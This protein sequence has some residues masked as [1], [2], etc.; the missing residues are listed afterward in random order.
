[1]LINLLFHSMSPKPKV[2]IPVG[3]TLFGV[4]TFGAASVMNR[5][6]RIEQKKEN[7][8][9]TET[10]NNVIDNQNKIR[11]ELRSVKESAKAIMDKIESLNN[12]KKEFLNNIDFIPTGED[13]MNFINQ[14]MEF[15]SS[16]PVDNSLLIFNILASLLILTLLISTLI[17]FYSNY[18]IAYFK[19][20]E[21]YPKLKIFLE[22][23]MKF[24]KFY[25]FY[26]IAISAFL[27]LF[28]IFLNFIILFNL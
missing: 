26:N 1:M 8:A 21:R 10:L 14:I 22:Y 24:Q 2:N 4:T 7:E 3:V 12:S 13:V 19:I 18:L 11:E 6:N 15:N 16:L 17:I 25:L 9:I 27:L 23:R 20:G 28:I 5:N